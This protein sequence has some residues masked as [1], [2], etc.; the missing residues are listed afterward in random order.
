MFGLACRDLSAEE[1]SSG[2]RVGGDRR[3]VAFALKS[4]DLSRAHGGRSSYKAKQPQPDPATTGILPLVASLARGTVLRCLYGVL[5]YSV[6]VPIFLYVDS[7]YRVSP[8]SLWENR[9]KQTR[10]SSHRVSPAH[11]LASLSFYR[12]DPFRN[13]RL[14]LSRIVAGFSGIFSSP[15]SRG[16]KTGD[17]YDVLASETIRYH[18]YTR[19]QG[20]SPDEAFLGNLL[21]I[22]RADI[23]VRG[24]G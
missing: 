11:L 10:L 3:T 9:R 19:R 2:R 20:D 23:S 12:S 15:R 17:S 7:A 4:A 1:T 13:S 21:E 14:P 6:Y 5:C 8:C 18:S 24:N 16:E 22:E